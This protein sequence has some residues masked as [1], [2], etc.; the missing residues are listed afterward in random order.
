M[1][2]GL[3]ASDIVLTDVHDLDD[4]RAELIAKIRQELAREDITCEE[5]RT[6]SDAYKNMSTDTWLTLASMMTRCSS[7]Y[8]LTKPQQSDESTEQ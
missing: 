6:L 1:E 3:S 4:L 2:S 5:I 8:G 7:G